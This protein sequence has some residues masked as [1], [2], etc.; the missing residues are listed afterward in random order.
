VFVFVHGELSDGRDEYLVDVEEVEEWDVEGVAWTVEEVWGGGVE[1]DAILQSARVMLEG[2]DEGEMIWGW[3]DSDW[4][5]CVLDFGEVFLDGIW[6]SI[7]CWGK[8]VVPE[9]ETINMGEEN[10]ERCVREIDGQ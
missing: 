6:Q 3:E 8:F 2:V 7:F 1:T 5:D 4:L 10:R 9:D